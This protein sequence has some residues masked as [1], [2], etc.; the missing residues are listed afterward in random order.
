MSGRSKDQEARRLSLGGDCL[1]NP[2]EALDED[3]VHVHNGKRGG[4]GRSAW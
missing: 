3:D 4:V 2:P 1:L